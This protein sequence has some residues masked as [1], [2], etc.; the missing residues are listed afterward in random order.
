MDE[1]Q[2]FENIDRVVGIE[3]RPQG[4]PAGVVPQLYTIARGDGAP[5]SYQAAQLL[6]A[7]GV[8]RVA[9]LTGII[10][11]PALP[12]GE[13]DGPVGAAVLAHALGQIGKTVDVAV[14]ALMM[15]ILEEIKRRVSGVFTVLDETLLRAESYDAAVAIE[16]LGQNEKGVTHAVLGK[17]VKSSG[18]A[19]AFIKA[20]NDA[21]KPTLGIGDGGN[22]IG[23]GAIF[24]DARKIVA[25]GDDCGCGCGGGI[26]TATSTQLLFPAN[27][28]NFG[29]YAIVTAIGV[30]QKLPLLLVS[31]ERVVAG[32]EACVSQGCLD[33][34]T[35]QPGLM[36][37]DGIPLTGVVAT[38][39]LLR[40]V[41][42]QVFAIS[43]RH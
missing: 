12:V 13:V 27:V 39:S 20:M 43:P 33:G 42:Q 17:E 5:L 18:V 22:E 1:L 32:I 25:R 6:C 10:D 4:L 29:C 35:F 21:G 3:M 26:V 23:F 41:A 40:T 8:E 9:V 11:E 36:Q 38:V 2:P 28:S 14:P 16:S 7:P 31:P 34:G 19:D 15:P 24:D 37:D 30:I